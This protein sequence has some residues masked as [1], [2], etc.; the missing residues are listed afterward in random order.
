MLI[1]ILLVAN[2]V[3]AV[4]LVISVLLQRSDG[5]MGAMSGGMGGSA[6]AQ[7]AGQGG[8]IRA[9]WV[10][11]AL[12][13]AN[14]LLLAVLQAYSHQ[15]TSVVEKLA[16]PAPTELLPPPPGMPAPAVQATAATLTAPLMPPTVS[17][18]TAQ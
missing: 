13:L 8:L 11:G 12:F 15:S 18:G 1:N 3:I 17:S 16:N 7:Q 10:L 2:I 4:F 5:G 9:T 14:C 6:L